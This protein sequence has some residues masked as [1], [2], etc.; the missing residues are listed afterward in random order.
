M[1]QLALLQKWKIIIKPQM[2]VYL[3]IMY[4]QLMWIEEVTAAAA[5]V[6]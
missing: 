4:H 1:Q 5:V 6:E 2:L 3:I